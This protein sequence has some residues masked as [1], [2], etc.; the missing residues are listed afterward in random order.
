MNQREADIKTIAHEFAVWETKL[1]NLNV[2]N[3]TD[4]NII[5]EYTIAAILNLIFGYQLKQNKQP[6][7]AAIDLSDVEN[8]IAFQITVTKSTQ[9][10]N[11]TVETFIGNGLH[12]NYDQ[13]F[14]LILGR[15]QTRYPKIASNGFPFDPARQVLDFQDLLKQ[16]TLMPSG[17]LHELALLVSSENNPSKSTQNDAT[18]IFK[19]SQ[20]IKKKIEKELVK[21]DLRDLFDLIYY[22]PHYKFIYDRLMVRSVEDRKYPDLDAGQPAWFRLELWDFYEYG[23]EFIGNG[24]KILFDNNFRWDLI[25]GDDDPRKNNPDYR[26][27]H[28]HSFMKIAFDDMVTYDPE[29]DGYHGYPSLYC[30]FRHNRQPFIEYTWGRMGDH[31]QE[32]HTF[33]FDPAKRTKL[34]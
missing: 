25:E 3:F 14:V 32:K 18:A 22:E 31:K 21:K 26:H 20:A 15:K 10:V 4:A 7:Q 34:P 13:L 33:K 8:R 9:K 5:A 19:K 29:T 6:N 1:A 30:H 12:H 23:L 17:R 16:V 24:R 11:Q 28:F 27:E 2:I